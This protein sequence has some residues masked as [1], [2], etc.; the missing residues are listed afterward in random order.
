MT[1]TET[2][3]VIAIVTEKGS[4][5]RSATVTVTANVT[6]NE[7]KKNRMVNT[8]NMTTKTRWTTIIWIW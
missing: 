2:V 5:T 8:P 3:I 1:V 6:E 4:V 7:L